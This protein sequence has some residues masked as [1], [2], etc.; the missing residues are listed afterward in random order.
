MQNPVKKRLQPLMFNIPKLPTVSDNVKLFLLAIFSKFIRF[1]QFIAFDLMYVYRH[2]PVILGLMLVSFLALHIFEKFYWFI[3]IFFNI[4]SF[5]IYWT[6]MIVYYIFY[7]LYVI[8]SFLSP[9]AASHVRLAALSASRFCLRMSRKTLAIILLPA[10]WCFGHLLRS[11]RYFFRRVWAFF[12]DLLVFLRLLTKNKNATPAEFI[13]DRDGVRISAQIVEDLHSG[14]VSADSESIEHTFAYYDHQGGVLQLEALEKAEEITLPQDLPTYYEFDDKSDMDS[15]LDIIG[16]ALNYKDAK[17]ASKASTARSKSPP[18]TAGSNSLPTTN[19][20][21]SSTLSKSKKDSSTKPDPSD[22]AHSAA[23]SKIP[24]TSND[25]DKVDAEQNSYD[26]ESY[27]PS[28][29]NSSIPKVRKT[30]GLPGGEQE[31]PDS[32]AKSKTDAISTPVL[33]AICLPVMAF[34]WLL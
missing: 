4:F 20:P 15:F 2:V 31:V 19:L 16:E 21:D 18:S 26:E 14:L 27:Q 30:K 5:I 29:Q 7:A 28:Q 33:F 32:E 25:A 10:F 6:A 34:A 8:L 13:Y 9:S 22:P 3:M 24:E 11:G 1:F 23:P 17:E 12:P